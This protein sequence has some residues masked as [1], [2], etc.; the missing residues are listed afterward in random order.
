M[1]DVLAHRWSLLNFPFSIN[2][3]CL[4]GND[5][6]CAASDKRFINWILVHLDDAA[7]ITANWISDPLD[8]G[9]SGQEKKI[10]AIA[11][12]MAEIP[13]VEHLNLYH[14]EDNGSYSA[15]YPYTIPTASPGRTAV[16]KVSTDKFYN[17]TVKLETTA[18]ITIDKI[19]LVGR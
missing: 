15:A 9:Y 2:D 4:D 10:S 3:F 5:L 13:Q 8:F 16:V 14:K 7:T 6:Y 19:T 18:A 1:Y 12:E 11:I 17:L